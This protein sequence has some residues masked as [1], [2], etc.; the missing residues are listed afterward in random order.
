LKPINSATVRKLMNSW[1]IEF[2]N[3]VMLFAFLLKITIMAYMTADIPPQKSPHTFFPSDS[4]CPFTKN[5]PHS[6]AANPA[7]FGH[8]SFS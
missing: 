7:T 2:S 5:T 3:P 1:S 8:V 6:T 4:T